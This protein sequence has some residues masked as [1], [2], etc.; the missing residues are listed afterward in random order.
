MEIEKSL[1]HPAIMNKTIIF[2][3][4]NGHDCGLIMIIINLNNIR[5]IYMKT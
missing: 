4:E 5:K 3:R 2:L 1:P